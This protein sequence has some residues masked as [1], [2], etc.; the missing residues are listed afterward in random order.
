MH[1]VLIFDIVHH[2][3]MEDARAPKARVDIHPKA[4]G[5]QL[6]FLDRAW[7]FFKPNLGLL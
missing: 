2:L 1:S 5:G 4:D 7:C 3:G 6:S